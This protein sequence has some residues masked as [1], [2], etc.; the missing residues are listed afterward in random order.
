VSCAILWKIQGEVLMRVQ[1]QFYI[2]EHLEANHALAMRTF[3]VRAKTVSSL[4]TMD[5]DQ[6]QTWAKV[7]KDLAVMRRMVIQFGASWEILRGIVAVIQLE[8]F[9]KKRYH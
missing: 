5:M 1:L 4:S 3:K 6:S 8:S 7:I 9:Q 2:P